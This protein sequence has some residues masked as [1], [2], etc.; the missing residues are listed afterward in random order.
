MASTGKRVLVFAALLYAGAYGAFCAGQ[1]PD[2][3]V[4]YFISDSFWSMWNCIGWVLLLFA[5]GSTAAAI[6]LRNPD[7][8]QFLTI[9][10]P[11]V[12]KR[13]NLFQ[14]IIK[15]EVAIL[16]FLIGIVAYEAAALF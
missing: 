6:A 16:T 14:I 7:D 8:S 11:P 5:L 10:D 12:Q 3:A 15:A 2:Q 1:V 9:A 4:P 13:L